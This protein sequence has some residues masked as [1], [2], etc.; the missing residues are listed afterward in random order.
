M[1]AAVHPD[2][3]LMDLHMPVVGGADATRNLLTSQPG[4]KVIML[5]A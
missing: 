5:T 3:V 4:V 1:A 2:M